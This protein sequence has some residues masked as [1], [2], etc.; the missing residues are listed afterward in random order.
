MA[1]PDWTIKII[2]ASFKFFWQIEKIQLSIVTTKS[3]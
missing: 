3:W 1:I 2:Q